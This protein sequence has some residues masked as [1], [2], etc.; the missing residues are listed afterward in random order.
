[1]TAGPPL[2]AAAWTDHG[3]LHVAFSGGADSVCLLKRLVEAG[4]GERVFALH[5]DH[6]LDPDSAERAVR[7][8]RIA[9]GF[10]VPF[11]ALVLDPAALDPRSGPEAAAR[12]ARYE[13]LAG[14]LGKGETPH[15]NT[16]KQANRSA[17]GIA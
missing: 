12:H 15:I 2:D 6:R 17:I 16:P 4:L 10:G 11:E 5:V 13:A 9:A 1:M 8:E 3:R 7:A 14:R